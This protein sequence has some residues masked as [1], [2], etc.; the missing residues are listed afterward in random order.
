MLTDKGNLAAAGVGGNYSYDTLTPIIC[1]LHPSVHARTHL[2]SPLVFARVS[3]LPERS[4][5]G[6]RSVIGNCD[7]D[8]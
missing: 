7:V 6:L 5:C 1:D 8:L 3:L 4:C 2:F